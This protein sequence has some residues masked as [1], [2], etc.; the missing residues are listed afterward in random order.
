MSSAPTHFY[1]QK[2]LVTIAH[3]PERAYLV[4][5]SA[6]SD[7]A[8]EDV[9]S[10]YQQEC[11]V[12]HVDICFTYSQ[13]LCGEY[14]KFCR[15]WN[16]LKEGLISIPSRRTFVSLQRLDLMTEVEKRSV[17]YLITY[18]QKSSLEE[19]TQAV[20]ECRASMPCLEGPG[21]EYSWRFQNHRCWRWPPRKID[22]GLHGL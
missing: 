2:P 7:S 6:A 18:G 22:G 21:L 4:V 5:R 19:R 12:T 14:V 20:G 13:Y 17:K 9:W 8:V 11:C 15:L 1:H 10:T 16:W 3:I